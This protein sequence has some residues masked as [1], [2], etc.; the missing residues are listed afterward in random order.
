MLW[1]LLLATIGFRIG[2]AAAFVSGRENLLMLFGPS[3]TK[4]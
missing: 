3:H 2:L 1:L 4:K